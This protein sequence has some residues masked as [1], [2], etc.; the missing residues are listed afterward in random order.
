MTVFLILYEC[1]RSFSI[2]L[3]VYF[4]FEPVLPVNEGGECE[5]GERRWHTGKRVD[6]PLGEEPILRRSDFSA[7]PDTGDNTPALLEYTHRFFRR[8][9]W[10]G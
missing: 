6:C 9:R 3:P 7:A 5:R 2:V 1:T 10:Q 4:L 8:E